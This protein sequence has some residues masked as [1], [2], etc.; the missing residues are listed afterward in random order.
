VAAAKLNSIL[1][2]EKR[3]RDLPG[4]AASGIDGHDKFPPNK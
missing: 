3:A 4:D 2:P 1:A